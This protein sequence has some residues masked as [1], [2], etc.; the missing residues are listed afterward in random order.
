MNFN[1]L[2]KATIEESKVASIK[3]KENVFY[4]GNIRSASL[5]TNGDNKDVIQIK[6]KLMG[7][8]VNGKVITKNLYYDE[9]YSDTVRKITMGEVL[10]LVNNLTD[11]PITENDTEEDILSKLIKLRDKTVWVSLKKT[12]D[13]N[14]PSKVF[15]NYI[16]KVSKPE[17]VE[18]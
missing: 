14:D 2:L 3:L 13:R 1:E 9:S 4:E 7:K 15:H 17:V 12:P 18:E 10:R 8:E 11:S 6:I 5:T 16:L